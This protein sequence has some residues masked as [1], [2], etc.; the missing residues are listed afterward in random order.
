M[1]LWVCG[2]KA[3]NRFFK[4]N[5][6]YLALHSHGVDFKLP[7][8]RACDDLKSWEILSEDCLSAESA[9]SAAP[10]FLKQRRKQAV[11]G[12]LFFGYFLLSKQKKVTRMSRD[13]DKLD[14]RNIW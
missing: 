13:S 8:C 1:G 7:C 5:K 10:N 12:A 9:S 6:I 11:G 4:F 2:F 14:W 3:L